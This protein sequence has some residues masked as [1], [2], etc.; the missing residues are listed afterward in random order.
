MKNLVRLLVGILSIGAAAQAV[1][2]YAGTEE[3]RE[4]AK[5]AEKEPADKRTGS[6]GRTGEGDKLKEFLGHILEKAAAKGE[7]GP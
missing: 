7:P 6:E 2:A 5:G 4:P 1:I 3:K